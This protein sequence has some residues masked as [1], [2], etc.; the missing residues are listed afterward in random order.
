MWPSLHR[1]LWVCVM[2]LLLCVFRPVL[3][4]LQDFWSGQENGGYPR[5]RRWKLQV[6]E[7]ALLIIWLS[8]TSSKST[9][10]H[11]C[12]E[13]CCGFYTILGV[14]SFEVVVGWG[15]ANVHNFL[16]LI[17]YFEGFLIWC[18][19]CVTYCAATLVLN[20]LTI[21]HNTLNTFT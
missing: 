4:F 10:C 11:N 8:A 5:I 14:P 3:L 7:T 6:C 1:C 16:F 15:L 2:C 9:S 19:Y 18:L 12:T 20:Y 13:I 17:F 21:S